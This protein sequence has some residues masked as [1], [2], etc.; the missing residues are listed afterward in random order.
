MSLYRNYSRGHADVRIPKASCEIHVGE[1][2]V[3]YPCFDS[4]DYANE[5]RTY[6][7]F[8]FRERPIT[9]DDMK[10]LSEL[11]SNSNECRISEDIPAEMLP[12]AYYVGDGSTMM[13]AK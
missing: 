2:W 9:Q 12:L 6:Q 10:R 5:N 4:D 8:V 13:V 7:N 3:P 11:P 1:L